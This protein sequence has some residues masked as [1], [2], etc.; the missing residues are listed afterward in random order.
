MTTGSYVRD[1]RV[2]VPR[3]SY[4][5][6]SD[7][8]SSGP[9]NSGTSAIGNYRSKTWGGANTPTPVRT[10]KGKKRYYTTL[11]RKGKVVTRVFYER[12]PKREMFRSPTEYD[13]SATTRVGNGGTFTTTTTNLT[14]GSWSKQQYWNCSSEGAGCAMS[15]HPLPTWTANEDIKLVGKL[16]EAMYGSDFNASVFLGEAHQ[17]L[18]MIGDSAV[19]IARALHLFRKGDV[20]GATRTLIANRRF[21]PKTKRAQT[22]NNWLELQYGWLPLL[23]DIR[24]GAELLAHQLHVPFRRRFRVRHSVRTEGPRGGA[25]WEYG[26]C[27]SKVSKQLIAIVSEPPSVAEYLG[28]M[29]PELVL[30]ELTPFSFVADWVVPIGSYLEARAFA[31]RLTGLFVTTTMSRQHAGGLRSKRYTSGNTSYGFFPSSSDEV[32]TVTMSRRLSTSV[33][34]PMPTI[35]AWEKVASWQ[36]C[37]NA[38]ALL[39]GL[40]A[41]PKQLTRFDTGIW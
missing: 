11:N 41:K 36:H 21:P 26:D 40:K 12:P 19:K 34:V 1:Y 14:N 35:K 32:T 23:Q 24:G 29:D 38:I 16:R 20:V 27:Y 15:F 18:N 33:S 39:T 13:M 9:S 22:G 7:G 3:V 28:V 5:T 8:W 25:Y 4:S 30:W 17:T 31:G 6:A 10:R 2:T 37:A